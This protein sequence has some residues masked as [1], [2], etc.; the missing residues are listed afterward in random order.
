[1]ERVCLYVVKGLLEVIR[2]E[3]FFTDW[4]ISYEE[5]KVFGI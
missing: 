3:T 5:D 1:M 2:V 4:M